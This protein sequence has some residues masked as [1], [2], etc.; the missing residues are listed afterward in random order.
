MFALRDYID[1]VDPKLQGMTLAEVLQKCRLHGCGV[2]VDLAGV[3]L[4]DEHVGGKYII[5]VT[6]CNGKV[7]PNPIIRK[8]SK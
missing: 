1:V 3:R 2:R 5:D 4:I 8:I 7:L 6:L